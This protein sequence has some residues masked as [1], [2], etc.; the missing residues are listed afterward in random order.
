VRDLVA[1]EALK[2]P[3]QHLLDPGRQLTAASIDEVELLLDPARE[4]T[5]LSPSVD[6]ADRGQGPATS[7]FGQSSTTSSPARP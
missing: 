3:W 2:R 1:A 6:V 7:Q 5:H 4:V